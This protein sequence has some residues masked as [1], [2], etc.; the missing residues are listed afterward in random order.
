[1]AQKSTYSLFR[2]ASFSIWGSPADPSVYGFVDWDVTER[3]KNLRNALLIKAIGYVIQHNPHLNSKLKFGRLVRRDSVD[4]SIMV[5]IP[6]KDGNDLTFTT[7]RQVDGLTIT[8]IN[9]QIKDRKSRIHSKKL[10]EVGTALKIIY[11]LPKSLGRLFLKLYSWLEFD[12]GINLG[13]LKLPHK[14][15]GAVII[16]NIGSLGLKKALL[17]LVPLTRASL[18]ISMGRAELEPKYINGE[19]QPREIIHLGITFDHRF[20]DGAEA[21]QMLR[22]FEKFLKEAPLI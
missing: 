10:D 5:N 8:E 14:P 22:D 17:P 2:K 11:F 9:E 7:I 20:F 12:L 1:M 19:L 15:F 16:S 13:F 3:P 4:V 21:A 6:G 18:L